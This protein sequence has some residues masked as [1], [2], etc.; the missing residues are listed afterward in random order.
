MNFYAG[1][2]SCGVT[3]GQLRALLQGF[4]AVSSVNLIADEYSDQ[5]SGFDFLKWK[6]KARA[7]KQA[8]HSMVE[9]LRGAS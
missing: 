8:R 3:E 7:R 6:G 2:R 1:N 9:I 4:E 5:S